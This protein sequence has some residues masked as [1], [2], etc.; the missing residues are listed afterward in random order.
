MIDLCKLPCRPLTALSKQ[1]PE[2]GTLDK[3]RVFSVSLEQTSLTLCW[4]PVLRSAK[5]IQLR[6]RL[7]YVKVAEDKT[8]MLGSLNRA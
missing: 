1:C 5:S 2:Y 6:Y 7:V 8:Q 3:T 4:N